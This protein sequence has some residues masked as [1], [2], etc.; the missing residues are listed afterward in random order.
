M[1]DAG[2]T[3]LKQRRDYYNVVLSSRGGKFFAGRPGNRLGKIEE[4]MIFALAEILRLEKFG[5]AD[6]FGAASGCVADALESFGK[7]LFGLR[8]A[9][10]LH[11]G[12]AKFV[13]GHAFIPL[14][15]NIAFVKKESHQ[16]ICEAAAFSFFCE[17]RVTQFSVMQP[18]PK[19]KKRRSRIVW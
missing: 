10:H 2:S 8:S 4:S 19:R 15:I 5:Q 17:R 1:I 6:H 18:E 7:I 12:Y 13:R 14:P 16:A 9:R 3:L 11:Q